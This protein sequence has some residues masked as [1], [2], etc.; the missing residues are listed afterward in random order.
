MC[1]R[2]LS[3]FGALAGLLLAGWVVAQPEQPGGLGRGAQPNRGGLGRGGR[4]AQVARN[5]WEYRVLARGQIQGLAGEPAKD[6]LT[7]GLNKLG[8]EGWELVTIDRG[9]DY[10]FKR[11]VS[12]GGRGWTTTAAEPPL[13]A[14]RAP[15]AATELR[16]FRLKHASA[17]D[18]ERLVFK[19]FQAG[20][21]LRLASEGRTNTLVVSGP[22]AELAE[23]EAVL[24]RLDTP[25]GAEGPRQKVKRP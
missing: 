20:G 15:A 8:S 22:A 14:Q 23:I 13:A 5:A 9:A 7:A 10:V 17:A 18:M 6:G 2:S 12:R 1:L 16:M 19:L 25:E 4:S 24:N 3:A 21:G 11:P